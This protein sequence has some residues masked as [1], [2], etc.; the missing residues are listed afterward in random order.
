MTLLTTKEAAEYL[1]LSM[2]F[3][4]RD[5]WQGAKVPFVRIGSRTVRYLKED[6]EEYVKTRRVGRHRG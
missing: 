2:A 4:E 3:L 5:R 6:L 1:G